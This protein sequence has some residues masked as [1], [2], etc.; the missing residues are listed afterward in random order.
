MEQSSWSLARHLPHQANAAVSCASRVAN[1]LQTANLRNSVFSAKFTPDNKY[2]L[3]G[4]DDG[5]IRL[6][7][8]NASDR[9]GVKSARQRT[10]LEY[11]QALIKRYSHMPEIRRIKRQRHLPKP[12]KKAGEIKNEEVAAIKR[13]EENI[14]KH[15]SKANLKARQNERQKMILTHEQ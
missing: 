8:S 7:R 12:I 6:W 14:R 11:D 2:I 10:K 5:N 4:S 9:S 1:Q 13:R 15:T 3:S